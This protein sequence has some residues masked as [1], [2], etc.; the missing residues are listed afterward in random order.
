[1]VEGKIVLSPFGALLT[2]HGILTISSK[3]SQ[4][5]RLLGFLP[6]D[7]YSLQ[8]LRIFFVFVF[9]HLR[10]PLSS[11]LSASTIVLELVQ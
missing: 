1:M 4:T 11:L 7:Y 8:F 9:V 2:G 6:A 10:N 5:R 3:I